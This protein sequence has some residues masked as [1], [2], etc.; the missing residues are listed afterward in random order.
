MQKT[1]CGEG[2]KERW[3]DGKMK[4]AHRREDRQQR[5][6]RGVLEYGQFFRR[7]RPLCLP[8]IVGI[9]NFEP[10]ILRNLENGKI[11]H[12][13]STLCRINIKSRPKSQ[14]TKRR[15]WI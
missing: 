13:D 9:Q 10:F 7:G 15:I 1:L 5:N 3:G 14:E 4:R 12:F 2:K 8:M 6:C 11:L